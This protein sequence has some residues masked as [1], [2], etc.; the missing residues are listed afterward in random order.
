MKSLFFSV[1]LFFIRFSII[2]QSVEQSPS[3]EANKNKI[4]GLLK[5]L[6]SEHLSSR[7]F[8]LQGDVALID[9]PHPIFIFENK[10]GKVY[11]QPMDGMRYLDQKNE[12]KMPVL[13]FVPQANLQFDLNNSQLETGK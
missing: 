4:N 13:K 8:S 7:T 10:M 1:M 2:A 6:K 3:T 11:R 5:Q 9:M 12:S